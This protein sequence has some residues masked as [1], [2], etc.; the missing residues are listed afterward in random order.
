LLFTSSSDWFSFSELEQ[1]LRAEEVG[2]LQRKLPFW[3][4]RRVIPGAA[5]DDVYGLT[6]LETPLESSPTLCLWACNTEEGSAACFNLQDDD[7][8]FKCVSFRLP[9]LPKLLFNYL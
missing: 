7:D 1:R 8:W 4:V 6:P 3:V 9:A 5:F 2:E